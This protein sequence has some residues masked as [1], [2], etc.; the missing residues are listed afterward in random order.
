MVF[1]SYFEPRRFWVLFQAK[2]ATWYHGVPSIHS[3]IVDALLPLASPSV[4]PSSSSSGLSDPPAP[5]SRHE[6]VATAR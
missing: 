1:M 2:G 4:P 3:A 6:R 5:P